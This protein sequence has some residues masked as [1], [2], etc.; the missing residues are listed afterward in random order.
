MSQVWCKDLKCDRRQH[1][2]QGLVVLILMKQV[3][4]KPWCMFNEGEFDFNRKLS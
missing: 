4:E 3:Y 1:L 2:C